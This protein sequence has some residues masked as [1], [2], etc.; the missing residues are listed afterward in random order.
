MSTAPPEK[1]IVDLYSLSLLRFEVSRVFGYLGSN[2]SQ[3]SEHSIDGKKFPAEIQIT[4]FNRNYSDI[5]QT[6][7]TPNSLVVIAFLFQASLIFLDKVSQK[8]A[9]WCHKIGWDEKRS[10]KENPQ[11]RDE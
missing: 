6:D 4:L 8:S 2:S 9:I 1:K 11:K 7:G 3:G 10:G 5:S